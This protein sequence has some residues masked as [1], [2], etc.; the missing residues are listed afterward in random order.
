MSTVVAKCLLLSGSFM[1][2]TTILW[3]LVTFS[4]VQLPLA[5]LILTTTL[6]CVFLQTRQLSD[7]SWV[8]YC[9]TQF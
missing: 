5:A 6:M 9:V 3:C 2:L 7:T 1:I 4:L 8:S